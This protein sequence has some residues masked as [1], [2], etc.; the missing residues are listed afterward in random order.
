MHSRAAR[1][2]FFTSA[3][4]FSAISP[5]SDF[6]PLDPLKLGSELGVKDDAVQFADAALERALAILIPEEL[7]VR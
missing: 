3:P 1:F 5:A 6:D 4:I 7:R 2:A